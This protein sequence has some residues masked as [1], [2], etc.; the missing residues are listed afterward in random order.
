MLRKLIF[1][2]LPLVAQAQGYTSFFTGNTANINTV[3]TFGVC[4]MGGATEND[5]A[6]KWL[7]QR[8]N[9]GDVVVIRSTGGNGYNNYFIHN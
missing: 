1:L 5:E 6:M 3:P 4:L 2:L 8:A 7:L 9:G